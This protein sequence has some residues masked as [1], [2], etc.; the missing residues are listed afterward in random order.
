MYQL[1]NDKNAELNQ[2]VKYCKCVETIHQPPKLEIIWRRHSPREV[3]SYE[4]LLFRKGFRG[5]IPL[6]ATKLG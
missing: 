1:L 2:Y 3:N 4:N 5:S 6:R